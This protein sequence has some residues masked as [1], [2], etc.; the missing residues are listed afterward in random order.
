[1]EKLN[2]H[3]K[4]ILIGLITGLTNGLFGSGGGTVLVP[5]LVFLMGVEDHKAHATAISIILPMSILS[6]FIYYKYNVV[7]LNLTLKV[8][9]GSVAGGVLGSMV[10]N[11]VPVNILRKFFGL[12]MIAA[13]V[14][15]VL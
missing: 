14:R 9:V 2:S 15:M 8:A 12:V 3:A 7:D 4:L 5:C 11:K 13:A 6:S 1:M 10:L